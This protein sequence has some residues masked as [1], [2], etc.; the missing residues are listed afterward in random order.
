MSLT[1][2]ILGA[3]VLLAAIAGAVKW[4]ADTIH[5]AGERDAA[6]A[7]VAQVE[8]EKADLATAFAADSKA[9]VDIGAELATFRGD[10][11]KGLQSFSQQLTAQPLTHE[12]PRETINGVPQPCHER[13]PVRYRSLFNAAVTGA[14]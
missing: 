10:L 14:P 5:K 11:A 12:V 1:A 8:R 2:K 9:D 13:E 4:A 7:R 3:L 6:V